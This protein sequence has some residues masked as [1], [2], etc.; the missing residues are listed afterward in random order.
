MTVNRGHKS[1]P[2]EIKVACLPIWPFALSLLSPWE[3]ERWCLE[4]QQPS[5]DHGV[6][7][8]EKKDAKRVDSK[9]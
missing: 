5:C 3:L 8:V 1:F 6:V 4:K 7:S 2:K 9:R